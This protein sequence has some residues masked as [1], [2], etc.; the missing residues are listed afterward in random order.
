[1]L[2]LVSLPGAGDVAG[3]PGQ[4]PVR[5]QVWKIY[6]F[7]EYSDSRLCMLFISM[8]LMKLGGFPTFSKKKT[9]LLSH[10]VFMILCNV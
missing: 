6:L 2:K 4:F 8:S 7:A 3:M 10:F 1:M 5:A 9:M